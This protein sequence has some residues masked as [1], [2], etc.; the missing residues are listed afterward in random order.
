MVERNTNI[1]IDIQK[2][3]EEQE[4]GFEAAFALVLCTMVLNI[5]LIMRN[6]FGNIVITK[7]TPQPYKVSLTL[8]VV[9]LIELLSYMVYGN[10]IYQYR[11][12]EL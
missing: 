3:N 6:R 5:T 8:L 10:L 4:Y 12:R 1:S 11:Y 7:L 9:L 2:E